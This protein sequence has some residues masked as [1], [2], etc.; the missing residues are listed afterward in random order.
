MKT[1]TNARI[2]RYLKTLV[3]CKKKVPLI[4]LSEKVDFNKALLITMI[5]ELCDKIL[6]E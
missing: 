5:K 3:N 4:Y 1:K 2:L 6:P